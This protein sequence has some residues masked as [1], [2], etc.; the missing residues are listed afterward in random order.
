MANTSCSQEA[1]HTNNL[2]AT[3][4][5]FLTELP[6]CLSF[7]PQQTCPSS[8]MLLHS[9]DPT[10]VHVA[11]GSPC[12]PSELGSSSAGSCECGAHSKGTGALPEQA[13]G[14]T[15]QPHS[16]QQNPAPSNLHSWKL[17]SFM[18]FV[19]ILHFWEHCF[20]V[21]HE[22]NS[23]KASPGR[24]HRGGLQTTNFLSLFFFVFYPNIQ[25]AKIHT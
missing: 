8:S 3:V 25:S 4:P 5:T 21:K 14:Q 13:A 2:P 11:F 17:T 10:W 24:G 15:E 16:S 18:K 6:A 12:N 22:A 9:H 19:E 23:Q 20:T 7:A 1:V